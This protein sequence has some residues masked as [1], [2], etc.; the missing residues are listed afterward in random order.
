MRGEIR[1]LCKWQD[2]GQTLMRAAMSQLKLSPGAY[3]RILN[4]SH[5]IADLAGRRKRAVKV[6]VSES[7]F[8]SVQIRFS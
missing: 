3:H 7:I 4:L 1:Q 6:E 5:T 2:D 8:G